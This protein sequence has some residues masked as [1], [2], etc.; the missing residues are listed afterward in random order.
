MSAG[1]R[2]AG[3][4]NTLSSH[5]RGG[6]LGLRLFDSLQGLHQIV[7]LGAVVDTLHVIGHGPHLLPGLV[8][9]TRQHL[10]LLHQL[11]DALVR[12]L[13]DALLVLLELLLHGHHGMRHLLDML[14]LGHDGGGHS[15]EHVF[16]VL[17]VRH[18]ECELHRAENTG[19]VSA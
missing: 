16:H 1:W 17:S 2:T 9:H 7:V 10:V 19:G 13:H 14:L 3:S 12:P 5:H 4:G 11:L 8:Q 18:V 6:L 15:A